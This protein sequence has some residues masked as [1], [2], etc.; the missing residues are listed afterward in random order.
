MSSSFDNDK[1]F[2]QLI[3][4]VQRQNPGKFLMDNMD[5]RRCKAQKHDTRPEIADKDETT[6]VL[7]SRDKDPALT[8]SG[9]EQVNIRGL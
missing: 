6:E 4:G 1:G 3:L 7:V 8:M 5:V 2:F 9:A